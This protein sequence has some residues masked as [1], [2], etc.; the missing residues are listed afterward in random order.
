M[1]KQLEDRADIELLVNR[2]YDNIRQ[3]EVLGVIFNDIAQVDWV[4]HLPKM[5]GFWEMILFNQEG[6]EGHPLRPHLALNNKFQL[7][8]E[9]F[10][11]WLQ[12]FDATVDAYFEG[13][14]AQEA[15]SRAKNV[16]LSWAYKI[17][18]LNVLNSEA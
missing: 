8:P 15:K 14:K 11:A 3:H 5:Y 13:E 4:H 18:Y 17:N 9:H 12:T 2:F 7:K 10:E 1:K 16:A 6:Y